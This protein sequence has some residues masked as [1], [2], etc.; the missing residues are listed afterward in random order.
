MNTL[1]DIQLRYQQLRR[2]LDAAYASLPW[3][4]RHIDVITDQMPPL[5]RALA[6]QLAGRPVPARPPA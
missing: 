5:E 6:G 3:D 4:S 2:E 1:Q